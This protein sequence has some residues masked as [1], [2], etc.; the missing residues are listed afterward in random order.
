VES[1]I[2]LWLEWDP[3]AA[4]RWLAETSFPAEIKLRW[5]TEK[6]APEY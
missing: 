5:L 4:K 2:R 3:E 1:T 6:L